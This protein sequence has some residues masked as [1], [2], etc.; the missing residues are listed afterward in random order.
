MN[1][2]DVDMEVLCMIPRAPRS[3]ILKSIVKDLG[4]ESQKSLRIIL[5]RLELRY[6]VRVAND[7]TGQGRTTQMPADRWQAARAAAEEYWQRVY[8][9]NDTPA[10]LKKGQR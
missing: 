4:L 2:Y 1:D 8:G 7:K 6:G 5:R 10:T 9:G 3:A